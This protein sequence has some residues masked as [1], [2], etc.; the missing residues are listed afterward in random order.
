MLLKILQIKLRPDY[1]AATLTQAVTERLEISASEITDIEIERRAIDARDRYKGDIYYILNL[2]V[3]IVGEL[4]CDGLWQVEPYPASNPGPTYQLKTCKDRPVI[5]GAGPAGLFAALTLARNGLKPILYEQGKTVAERRRDVGLF[6]GQGILNPQSNVLYGEGGAGTFSDGKITSRSKDKRRT[7]IVREALHAAG[8]K[9]EVLYDAAFHIGSDLLAQIIPNIRREICR[10]GGEFHFN[11]RLSGLHIENGKLRGIE[12]DNNLSPATT[13][14]LA[15]GHSAY[16]TYHMLAASGIHLET[17]P[18]AVGLRVELPQ[19]AINRSQYGD[20]EYLQQ[21]GAASFALTLGKDC[22][23]FCM[24][25]GGSIIPC[26]TTPGRI[27]TN[28]MSLSSRS[29][30]MGNAAFLL[31]QNFQSLEEG[32]HFIDQL[33]CAAFNQVGSDYYL[34]ATTLSSFPAACTSLPTARSCRRSKPVDF[35]KILPEKMYTDLSEFIPKMLHKMKGIDLD[36]VVIAGPETRSSAPVR[37]TRDVDMQSTNLKGLYPVGEGA[38][39]AGG[40]MSSAIDG[41]KAAEALLSAE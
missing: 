21:L 20:T 19:V 40:I 38:G 37:I 31:P 8:A 22:Y 15:I 24:C 6:W 9:E 36:S 18:F 11:K 23:T 13:C 12:I 5:I 28:G 4:S 17:K 10:L 33:E 14:I 7:R 35:T 30:K 25:P 3:E 39:Y 41:I 29:G 16:A 26:A 1:T 34:P 32:L 2:K 27:F